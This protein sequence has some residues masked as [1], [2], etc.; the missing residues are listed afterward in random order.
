MAL[1][2]EILEGRFRSPFLEQSPASH[3]LIPEYVPSRAIDREPEAPEQPGFGSRTL[4][5][6]GSVLGAPKAGVDWVSRKVS[7]DL[8]KLPVSEQ[9][10]TGGMLRSAL[11]LDPG[12]WTGKS[13]GDYVARLGGRAIEFAGDIG[14][15]PLVGGMGVLGKVVRT[16]R[17]AGAALQAGRVAPEALD[18]LVQAGRITPQAAAAAAAAGGRLTPE[19][20]KA[21]EAAIRAAR[22][23]RP[24]QI[25]MEATFLGTM[26]PAAVQETAAAV[27]TIRSEGLT[28]KAA[29]EVLGASLS[30]YMAGQITRGIGRNLRAIDRPPT[31]TPVEPTE[32][33]PPGA[34]PMGGLPPG[35]QPGAELPPGAPPPRLL[36]RGP[37]ITRPPTAEGPFLMPEAPGGRPPPIRPVE[38]AGPIGGRDLEAQLAEIDQ[39]MAGGL[40]AARERAAQAEA[41]RA[42]GAAEA[43]RREVRDVEARR[44]AELTAAYAPI[45]RRLVSPE[46]R[47]ELPPGAEIEAP[48]IVALRAALGERPAPAV[49]GEVALPPEAVQAP[50]ALPARRIEAPP[51]PLPAVATAP[52]AAGQPIALPEPTVPAV[53]APAP[54]P[55]FRRAEERFELPPGFR[56]TAHPAPPEGA[57]P[58]DAL[59]QAL[60]EPA[61][62]AAQDIS[63][64][65]Q[66]GRGS[67]EDVDRALATLPD[68]LRPHAEAIGRHA[69]MDAYSRFSGQ[70]LADSLA[71]AYEGR[72]PTGVS[73]ARSPSDPSSYD[74]IYRERN[75]IQA[76]AR[77]VGGRVT[78]VT[79]PEKAFDHVDNALDALGATRDDTLTLLGGL[80][81]R[82]RAAR[83]TEAERAGR[84]ER[85][86]EVTGGPVGREAARPQPGAAAARGVAERGR[87]PEPIPPPQ[88]AV[89]PGAA[90]PGP[91]R[92]EPTAVEPAVR[93][94]RLPAPAP[95]QDIDAIHSRM[96]NLLTQTGHTPADASRIVNERLDV[97]RETGSVPSGT[98]NLFLGSGLDEAAFRVF[99]TEEAAAP[100]AAARETTVDL[101]ARAAEPTPSPAQAEAGNYRKGHTKLAGLDI[102]IE[103]PEGSTRSGVDAG[104]RPWTVQMRS[105]YGYLKGF[106]GRDK[107]HIDVFIRPGTPADYAGPVFV[108]N[109]VRPGARTTFDEHKVMI[110]WPEEASARRGYLEN[111]AKGWK[112]LGSI[113]RYEMPE[114]KAWLESDVNRMKPAL[115]PAKARQPA[116][117]PRVVTPQVPPPAA[118]APGYVLP[119]FVSKGLRPEAPPRRVEP[120]PRMAEAARAM[121]A[122]LVGRP[123]RAEAAAAAPERRPPPP[124]ERETPTGRS[125]AV[126]G[127]RARS[128][129]DLEQAIR[130]ATDARGRTRWDQVPL[131]PLDEKGNPVLPG[132]GHLTPEQRAGL[133]RY[134]SEELRKAESLARERQIIRDDQGRV[135]ASRQIASKAGGAFEGMPQGPKE[136]RE[137][138]RRDKGN[139]VELEM[140]R[141]AEDF[142]EEQR[143]AHE[144]REERAEPPVGEERPAAEKPG[145]RP[146][147]EALVSRLEEQIGKGRA[148]DNKA[149]IREA[150]A[151]FG[152]TRGEGRYEIRDAYDALEVAVNRRLG[153]RAKELIAEEPKAA[154]AKLRE[155][156]K[157]LPTQAERTREQTEFQQFS[158][159]PTHAFVAAKALAPRAGEV[160][161]EPSAGTGSLAVIPRALGAVV[162][163]NE[164]AP[165]RRG[166]LEMMGFQ[167][168][169]VDGEQLHNL[170][171]DD[172][173][174]TAIVM[175]PPFSATGGRVA[176]H[177]T[178][179][180]AR[181][182]EQA[183]A[184]LEP[185][186]RL[187]A[188]LGE[189]MALERPAFSK[190]WEKTMARFNV[191]A[192]VGL[193]G[194]EYGKYGTTFGNQ[195]VVIDKTGPTPGGSHV[196]R[197]RNVVRGR[198]LSLEEAVDALGP[199][200]ETRPVPGAPAERRAEVGVPPGEVPGRARGPEP[201]AERGGELLRAE[202]AARGLGEYPAAGEPAGAVPAAVEGAKPKPVPGPPP[203]ERP[204]RPGG[205]RAPAPRVE[206]T[207]PAS[208]HEASPEGDR[209]IEARPPESPAPAEPE[210]VSKPVA[211]P[212]ERTVVGPDEVE[213][214]EV[215]GGT[216]VRYVP[217]RLRGTEGLYKHPGEIVEAAS[218]AAVE[219]PAIT[220]RSEYLERIARKGDISDIQYESALYA[221]QRA[222]RLLPDGQRAG[223]FVGDGTGVG[224]GRIISAIVLNN[225]AAGRKRAIWVSVSNDLIESAGR[226]LSDLEGGKAVSLKRI[227][228]WGAKQD[229]DLADGVVFTT[230][231]SLI[232]EGKG[233]GAQTRL[234]QLKKWLDPK[235]DG[236]EGAVIVFDEAHKAKNA[237]AEGRAEPT[238]TGLAVVKIQQELLPKARVLYS[239]ATGATDVR[240]MAYMV[241]LGLWGKGSAFPGGFPEFLSEIA[242]GGV[243][244]ME[245]AARDLKA[246]GAYNSRA[247]TYEGVEYRETVHELTTDQRRIYADTA[248]A[249]QQVLQNVDRA[250][251]EM[252]GGGAWQ[253]KNA[254]TQFWNSH[255]RFYRTLLTAFKMPTVLKR[256]EQE[257]KDGNSVVIGLIGTGE[258]QATKKAAQVVAEGGSL[259]EVDFSPREVIAQYLQKS[260]PVEQYQE[261]ASPTDPTKTIRTKVL[262]K[263]GNPVLNKEAV[264]VRDEMLDRLSDLTIPDSPLDQIL[265][266]FGPAKVAEI[267]GRSRRLIRDP[268]TG[269]REW[270]RRSSKGVPQ[271][272]VNTHEMD[273]FQSGK[274]RVAVIS[275]AGST[276]I[277][278]HAWKRA[279]NKQRRVFLTA[280]L[281]WSADQQLQFF[282]RVHRSDQ[283][284]P[285]IFDLI[286]TSAGGEKRFSSTIAR[287]LGSLGALSKGQ[288]DATGGGELAKYNFETFEGEAALQRLYGDLTGRGEGVKGIEDGPGVLVDM[289]LIKERG[290]TVDGKDARDV[291]RFL[292]RILALDLDRQNA[293]FD[294]FAERFD[295][296][297]R[298]ARENGTFDEG[299]ASIKGKSIRFKGEPATIATDETTGAKTFHYTLDVDKPTHPV[300]YERVSEMLD[301]AIEKGQGPG[302][303]PAG[304]FRQ[305]RSKRIVYAERGADRT[306]P[307]TGNIERTAVVTTVRELRS[308]VLGE[309]EFNERYE[310]PKFEKGEAERL[311]NEQLSRVKPVETHEVHVIGG[312]VLPLWSRLKNARTSK[313]KIVRAVADDGRRAVGVQIPKADVGRVLREI[314]IKRSLQT[315]EEVF[316]AVAENEDTVPLVE[317][318]ELGP[319]RV[320]G[321]PRLELRG[322]GLNSYKFGELRD[323]GLINEQIEWKQRFFVP[324]DPEAGIPIMKRLLDR[325]P[326]RLEGKDPAAEIA[327]RSSE[328][329]STLIFDD[330]ARLIFDLGEF[331]ARE[332]KG[333]GDW[334]LE[335]LRRAGRY[336]S[337]LG[338]HLREVWDRIT[339]RRVAP[340]P[341]TAQPGATAAGRAAAAAA[342][343]AGRPPRPT[344]APAPPRPS[345][346][347][348]FRMPEEGL[349]DSLIRN[350]QDKFIRV[351]RAQEA[352]RGAGRQIRE[353]ADV[354]ERMEAFEARAAERLRDVE[355]KY[356]Q[357]LIDGLAREGLKLEDLDRYL[358]A[359]HA[360]RRNEVIL[361][362]SDGAIADGSG[363][364]DR[365]AADILRDIDRQG[366][367]PKLQR[368]SRI[369]REVR[370]EQL[371]V[372]EDGDLISAEQAQAW[373]Q[374]MG[375]DY[376]P[377]R[378]VEVEDG[379]GTGRGFDIRG[380]ESKIAAGRAGLADSP[381]TFLLAQLQR[382]VVRAEKNR[383][384]KTFGQLVADHPDPT[385]WEQDVSHMRTELGAD[386]KLRQVRDVLA[387]QQ[388]FKFKVNGAEHRVS[389]KD[390][391]LRRAME[392]LSAQET[393]AFLRKVGNLTRLY[394]Q[395]VTAWSPEFVA[396]N[397]VRDVQ[398]AVANVTAEQS[399]GIARNMVKGIPGAIRGMY[400]SL[401]NQQATGQWAT[402]AREYR[403]AGGTVGWYQ[404]RSVPEMER[405]IESR[406][407]AA[408]PGVRAG[409]RRAWSGAIDWIEDINKAVENG[410]RLALFAALRDAG[411]TRQKAASVAKN[412]TLN[413]NRKGEAGPAIN[414]LYAFF[415]ANIQGGKRMID[416][417]RTPRGRLIAAGLIGSGFALDQWNRAQ[418]GDQDNDGTNDYDAVPEYIKDRN[419]V[420][421]RGEG[422]RP[423]LFPMPYG[424][425][426]VN[427]VGRNAGAA[428]SGAITPGRAA[429][430][431]A[432]ALYNAFN[433]LGSE[434]DLVQVLSPTFLDPIV[435]DVMNR[436]FTGRAI[437]PERFPGQAERPSSEMYYKNVPPLAR[438]L[439]K[440]LNQAT[441]GD[442]VTPG[443]ISVSPETIQHYF[444]FATGG[445]GR[446]GS[447][448]AGLA[449]SLAEGEVPSVR[450]VP[451][452]RRFVYEPTEGQQARTY[453]DNAQEL[454]TLWA[455]YK[456]YREQGNVEA[457]AGLPQNML[458]AKRYVD[459]ID[460][461]IRRLRQFGK[462]RGVDYEPQIRELQIRA[463]RLVAQ[464]R[465]Q[466]AA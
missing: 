215:P 347:A 18:A 88:P 444:N 375:E 295:R 313:L 266:N 210:A 19:V 459:R 381:T 231:N 226:D 29:E 122:E 166:L 439:A 292:N 81:R 379:M 146:G 314:G 254:M 119:S 209:A 73:I 450:N 221:E 37:L 290:T 434:A 407:R 441:G 267:T 20:V 383:V 380:R 91:A 252:T 173:R 234:D 224:K 239:S 429:A 80:R 415:N 76:G 416:V 318:L 143:E 10:T 1:I 294:A 198:M 279:L 44:Q 365:Q 329:G 451:F 430:N 163:T 242:G 389:I 447:N 84:L 189:G 309:R 157:R 261:V 13:A 4:H 327:R 201:A 187:V 165:R 202:R 366:Q 336:V 455:R 373:R 288:R 269:K 103:N 426:V 403:E 432:T 112:G 219:S 253:R 53:Q 193:P 298:L 213:R 200:S 31:W 71:E 412:V 9:A 229:I 304:F 399:A 168:T 5:A 114:F 66:R 205:R 264:A 204:L 402:R 228:E 164:V 78:M 107:D 195:L 87:A 377:L 364:S 138:L 370:D 86:V 297:V 312:S 428:M 115:P 52:A 387:D 331:V 258:S 463:N 69:Q 125:M 454:E 24:A 32:V 16:G 287:R 99:E 158:T 283:A 199:V 139:A 414:S 85:P 178:K 372:L 374:T 134:V 388:D 371:R 251:G 171:P 227:N 317:N 77:V 211:E 328:E 357:P 296:A 420:F 361:E 7:R 43:E 422:R 268:K 55:R 367:T 127:E 105:H 272:A 41:V 303:T 145:V 333:F 51:E 79:G 35:A 94:A 276:G 56:P 410:T 142:A 332:V 270:L 57:L 354:Y 281:S 26:V 33:L 448:V 96:V 92:V 255:Q 120:T 230:Y 299:V 150:E 97:M 104:G 64:Q 60:R 98:Q 396:T 218:M 452:A 326:S 424:W 240:N 101:E 191:R 385:L 244:A 89:T 50:V 435:Q 339:A 130:S 349:G 38:R 68:A 220:Y 222:Q 113:T 216:F 152:G 11:G 289:G 338:D 384:A 243:G 40:P 386:G 217:E 23:A 58:L 109:Q 137:A 307:K 378:T 462:R 301:K 133:T 358:Y 162:R 129:D 186:G 320:R 392:N 425:N 406:V 159:P 280:E 409:V 246:V 265:N 275:G 190:W 176:A 233:E 250:I 179:F 262:D 394:S 62:R 442:Q 400:Q 36:P 74:V 401:R 457:A 108:V 148:L 352:I 232:S 437:R 111:Y 278:L 417:L 353:E 257:L 405:R 196:E 241:R 206:P 128:V 61:R 359:K 39:L 464:A 17:V 376:V 413:F 355:Q 323:M 12:E 305:E 34:P 421:M 67:K 398:Q 175:N 194:E 248:T 285:P 54:P 214:R 263:D 180:G 433:P 110:G 456:T 249:W 42:A 308:E 83:I 271:S 411:A 181:H 438:E 460:S 293:L 144:M 461:Q 154:L 118:A 170:L 306:D 282:G 212:A 245:M 340:I 8:L 3:S 237:L 418:A 90:A 22:I 465:G 47:I 136:L 141:R 368:L 167:T 256:A 14:T 169:G 445:L 315:P 351:K 443:Y 277:S 324:S 322:P 440:R 46:R 147:T 348:G 390:P 325:Y 6:I 344:A 160:V 135:V 273:Q 208:G 274:K 395:L 466:G 63:R 342:P 140:R 449:V 70:N 286:S 131:P 123:R 345:P 100:P 343:P 45:A 423:L 161:L 330:L 260:F 391:L 95:P 311:W 151:A 235:G 30:A 356:A 363:L 174:P 188:I 65:I 21:S 155:L 427:A 223:Y 124:P 319:G 82:K 27:D 172:I 203:A 238:K 335:M 360:P 300:K 132:E 453:R 72:G 183:L 185:G 397:L 446:F 153:E 156:M 436:D 369:V 302:G 184:R 404:L 431:T 106:K 25:G 458:R 121:E 341:P 182:V 102:S 126:R 149:L 225:R 350:L 419:L 2:D 259:D 197:L 15:D 321:E 247:L 93:P 117:Q 28:P 334:S 49:V 310:A 408:G 116:P 362:R 393:G 284:A 207:T 48:D 291:P 59:P 236:G 192:N 337:D 75:K 316:R 177:K 382:A 346:G